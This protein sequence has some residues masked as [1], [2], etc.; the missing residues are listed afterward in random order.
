[1]N[2]WRPKRR[3]GLFGNAGIAMMAVVV[4]PV[5]VVPTYAQPAS[6]SKSNVV[7][8]ITDDL[9][10]ADTGVYGAT[11]IRTP[12]IDGLAKD[13]IRMTD[14]YSNGVLCTPTRAGLISG[15]YQQRYGIEAAYGG[16]K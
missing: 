7:L 9:G 4:I 15:R 13:G 3:F 11:D 6:E 12:N 8:I 1:M 10:Y 2:V 14:F 16:A 5:F